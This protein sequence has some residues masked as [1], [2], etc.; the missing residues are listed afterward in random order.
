MEVSIHRQQLL[1]SPLSSGRLD[2]HG[3]RF[4]EKLFK[5]DATFST[6][7]VLIVDGVFVGRFKNCITTKK[8][9]LEFSA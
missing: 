4:D 7:L 3:A 9:N 1:F 8:L 6:R 2:D 5:H